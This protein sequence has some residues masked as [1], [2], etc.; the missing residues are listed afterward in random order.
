MLNTLPHRDCEAALRAA[1]GVSKLLT[2]MLNEPT[3]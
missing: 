2:K 1:Q 3:D